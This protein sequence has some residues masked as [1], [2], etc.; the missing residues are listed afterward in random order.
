MSSSESK[1][2]GGAGELQAF[3]AGDLGDRAVGAEVAAQDA[4]VAG[5]FDRLFERLD[6]LLALARP[7]SSSRFSA[8]VLPVTVMQS[9]S[10]SPFRAAIFITAGVPPTSWRSS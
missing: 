4:D 6:D 8:I 7:W 10:R 3:L 5:L 9:P 1:H 2:V